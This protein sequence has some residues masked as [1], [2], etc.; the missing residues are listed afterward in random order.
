MKAEFVRSF[1]IALLY[2]FAL[3]K[4][5]RICFWARIYSLSLAFFFEKGASDV[6]PSIRSEIVYIAHF[7]FCGRR[8]RERERGGEGELGREACCKMGFHNRFSYYAKNALNT[9]LFGNRWIKN[10]M[11]FWHAVYRFVRQ[12]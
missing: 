8:E 1:S 3:F 4:L 12:C 7:A 10:K 11:Y 2:N 6:C 9:K 5:Q